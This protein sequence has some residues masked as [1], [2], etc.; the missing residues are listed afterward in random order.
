MIGA[1]TRLS[2][3]QSFSHFLQANPGIFAD[4]PDNF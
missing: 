4:S 3:L 1:Q 2:A